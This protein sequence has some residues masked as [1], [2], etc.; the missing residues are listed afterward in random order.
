MLSFSVTSEKS[1]HQLYVK[2]EVSGE[3][4]NPDSLRDI[5]RL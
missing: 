3:P 4:D 1:V 2:H 5:Q